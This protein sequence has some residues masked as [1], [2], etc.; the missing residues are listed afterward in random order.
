VTNYWTASGS[1]IYSNNT[2]NV[3][4]GTTTP[5]VKLNVV[6]GASGVETVLLEL[7]SNFDTANTGTTLK[8]VNST[9]PGGSRGADIAAIRGSDSLTPI[10]FRNNNSGGN[11]MVEVMRISGTGNVGIGTNA[12]NS[13]LH[14]PDGKYAQL[15]DNNAGAPPAAD[16]NADAQRGRISLD[17]TNNRLYIC[18]GATRG[19]DYVALTN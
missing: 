10:I 7:R 14:V 6:G 4:I 1:H 12:P 3:G 5:N 8:F 13:G 17:T 18:M 9:T 19:W 16:C 15:E 2:D 11:A